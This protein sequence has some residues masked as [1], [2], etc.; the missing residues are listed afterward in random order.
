MYLTIF[1]PKYFRIVCYN[2]VKTCES[3]KVVRQSVHISEC[4]GG[5][6]SC[7]GEGC[8]V[9]FCSSAN[10]ARHVA[11][12]C[13]FRSAGEYES[14]YA[15]QCLVQAVYLFFQAGESL[16]RHSGGELKIGVAVA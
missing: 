6:G 4:F 11:T 14:V 5:Y 10:G 13:E 16:G 2:I 12:C 3:E 1:F 9:A 8:D 7:F 15:G